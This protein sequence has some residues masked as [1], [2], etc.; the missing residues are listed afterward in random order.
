MEKVLSRAADQAQCW[1]AH[2][3]QKAMNEFNGAVAPEKREN[4]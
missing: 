1:V 4:E 3:I 2:G